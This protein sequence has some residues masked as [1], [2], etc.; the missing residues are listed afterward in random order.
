[1]D[2]VD[3]HI[4]AQWSARVYKNK[5]TFVC[6]P[7]SAATTDIALPA[8]A[9]AANLVYPN[10]YARDVYTVQ[11]ATQSGAVLDLSCANRQAS[12]KASNT[13]F[14]QAYNR[15][16][17]ANGQVFGLAA[18]G[19]LYKIDADRSTPLPLGSVDGSIIEIVPQQ[20]FEFFEQ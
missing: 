15:V 4:G 13:R 5:V 12:I 1:A 9:T 14:D 2:L 19:K 16:Y 8:G 7:T 20:T 10:G 18:D 3:L 17:K 6:D 11:L